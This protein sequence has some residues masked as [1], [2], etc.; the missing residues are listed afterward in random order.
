MA[1][2]ASHTSRN[3][4]LGA[5]NAGAS[6]VRL[7][8]KSTLSKRELRVLATA[9]LQMMIALSVLV[10]LLIYLLGVDLISALVIAFLVGCYGAWLIYE[11]WEGLKEKKG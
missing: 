4:S 10:L 9:I 8:R 11:N 7:M 6:R 2:D 1:R 5:V 3:D